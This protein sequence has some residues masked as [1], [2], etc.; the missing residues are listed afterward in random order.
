MTNK[1]V[2]FRRPDVQALPEERRPHAL[3][4]AIVRH[5]RSLGDA[6]GLNAIGVHYVRGC[7]GKSR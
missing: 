5:T 3:N 4:P 7:A 2:L 6:A 1:P